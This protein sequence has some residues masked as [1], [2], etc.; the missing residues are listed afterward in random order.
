MWLDMVIRNGTLY[1]PIT[2]SSGFIILE[3]MD[4]QFHPDETSSLSP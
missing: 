3:T 2:V 4:T 1:A